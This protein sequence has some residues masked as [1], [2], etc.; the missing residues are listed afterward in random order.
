MYFRRLQLMQIQIHLTQ[1]PV[2]LDI[3]DQI[4]DQIGQAINLNNLGRVFASRGEIAKGQEF[5]A[6]SAEKFRKSGASANAIDAEW[7][8]DRARDEL[9]AT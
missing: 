9:N 3:Y 4:G 8:L 1:E 7:N 2:A 6:R 5:F